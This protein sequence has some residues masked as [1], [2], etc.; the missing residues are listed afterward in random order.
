MFPH[1]LEKCFYDCVKDPDTFSPLY[2]T[3]IESQIKKA[4]ILRIF[5]IQMC[6]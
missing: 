3:R 5:L 2:A 4:A 6:Y 1:I